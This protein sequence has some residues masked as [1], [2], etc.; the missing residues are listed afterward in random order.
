MPCPEHL[1]KDEQT[2]TI[3]T[4][5]RDTLNECDLTQ[6]FMCTKRVLAQNPLAAPDTVS[7]SPAPLVHCICP[8]LNRE[9]IKAYKAFVGAYKEAYQRIVQMKLLTELPDGSL[10]PTACFIFSVVRIGKT[11]FQK[12]NTLPSDVIASESLRPHFPNFSAEPI[13]R[14]LLG[15]NSFKTDPKPI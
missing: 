7:R 3:R 9:F 10:P 5:S 11:I 13:M 6:R 8:L 14:I 2:E 15:L 12:S 1:T 4:L